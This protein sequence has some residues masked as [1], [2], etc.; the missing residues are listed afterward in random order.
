MYIPPGVTHSLYLSHWIAP[1]RPQRDD[2]LKGHWGEGT[3][4]S[5]SCAQVQGPQQRHH[6]GFSE[7]WCEQ[8]NG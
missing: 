2:F 5:D 4:Q 7:L 3:F 6:E 8:S 1:Q